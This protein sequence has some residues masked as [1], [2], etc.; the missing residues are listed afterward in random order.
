MNATGR[1]PGKRKHKLGGSYPTVSSMSRTYGSSTERR[2]D[3]TLS[4]GR[5][6]LDDIG[7]GIDRMINAIIN[8]ELARERSWDE[9]LANKEKER[10]VVN[11]V[12][13]VVIETAEAVKSAPSAI[14]DFFGTQHQDPALHGGRSYATKGMGKRVIDSVGETFSAIGDRISKNFTKTDAM[15]AVTGLGAGF[16]RGGSLVAGGVNSLISGNPAD[17]AKAAG[18]FIMSNEKVRKVMEKFGKVM[19]KILDP[20]AEVFVPVFEALG[21][22]LVEFAEIINSLL[23]LFQ[24]LAQA[25]SN[26]ARIAGSVM[27]PIGSFVDTVMNAA[28]SVF[29]GIAG[30]F[31]GGGGKSK[32]DRISDS[33]RSSIK[34]I[35]NE[36][37]E[38]FKRNDPFSELLKGFDA[39]YDQADRINSG[40]KKRGMKDEIDRARAELLLAEV[41][42]D[43]IK[44]IRSLEGAL[45]QF[46]E[47]IGLR[48]HQVYDMFSASGQLSFVDAI[49]V[50]GH[51]SDI[52]KGM[53]SGSGVYA[54]GRIKDFFKREM[55]LD[56]DGKNVLTSNLTGDQALSLFIGGQED[57]HRLVGQSGKVD[58]QYIMKYSGASDRASINY[59]GQSFVGMGGLS[60]MHLE[61]ALR[62]AL[63]QELSL[64]TYD[65]RSGSDSSSYTITS[66]LETGNAKDAVTDIMGQ[67]F[68]DT[69]IGKLMLNNALGVLDDAAGSKVGSYHHY[70]DGNTYSYGM[71]GSRDGAQVTGG[72]INDMVDQ[73]LTIPDLFRE[74]V[75]SIGGILEQG[76]AAFDYIAADFSDS[77][78]FALQSVE[79]A[80]HDFRDKDGNINYEYDPIKASQNIAD[81]SN[82][83]SVEAHNIYKSQDFSEAFRQNPRGQLGNQR[84]QIA[85]ELVNKLMGAEDDT[86]KRS[87]G[88]RDQLSK[89]DPVKDAD[90]YLAVAK[91]IQIANEEAITKTLQLEIQKAESIRTQTEN[92]Q[93]E[94]NLRSI[95]EQQASQRIQFE[96]EL[97][98][99]GLGKFTNTQMSL[100][101]DKYTK[102]LQGLTDAF[103]ERIYT[104]DQILKMGKE[105]EEMLESQNEEYEKLMA[106]F[107]RKQLIE[108]ERTNR[109][110]QESFEDMEQAAAG[111]LQPLRGAISFLR[112]DL[113]DSLKGLTTLGDKDSIIQS[114]NRQIANAI[115]DAGATTAT[116]LPALEKFGSDIKAIAEELDI[117]EASAEKLIGTVE[118]LTTQQEA[119]TEAI[120]INTELE[121][122]RAK[123]TLSGSS[124]LIDLIDFE[125]RLLDI[126]NSQA[127]NAP[128]L[129]E[130]E[131]QLLAQR[132]TEELRDVVRAGY[133]FSSSI[134]SIQDTYQDRIE[135]NAATMAI[136]EE[137]GIG[138]LS[139]D[140]LA[141]YNYAKTLNEEL[142]KAMAREI[143]LENKKILDDI[144]EQGINYSELGGA[145][146]SFIGNLE[147]IG[148]AHMMDFSLESLGKDITD[149]ELFE[150]LKDGRDLTKEQNDQIHAAIAARRREIDLI[151]KANR[152]ESINKMADFFGVEDDS[153]TYSQFVDAMKSLEETLKS[154]D[155]TMEDLYYSDF[156]PTPFVNKL[157]NAEE[158]YGQLYAAAM[159]MNEDG[160]YNAEAI[161]EFQSYVQTYL[162][163]QRDIYKSSGAYVAAYEKVQKDLQDV[164]NT[165]AIYGTKNANDRLIEGME[166]LRLELIALGDHE[167]FAGEVQGLIGQMKDGLPDG[168]EQAYS[169]MKTASTQ[170]NVDVDQITGQMVQTMRNAAISLNRD[171][172]GLVGDNGS[173]SKHISSFT[174]KIG[175]SSTDPNTIPGAFQ[176]LTT[177]IQ[178]MLNSIQVPEVATAQQDATGGVN[179]QTETQNSGTKDATVTTTGGGSHAPS[180]LPDSNSNFQ[181]HSMTEGI[182]GQYDF[183]GNKYDVDQEVVGKFHNDIGGRTYNSGQDFIDTAK[184]KTEAPLT[185]WFKHNNKYYAFDKSDSNSLLAA[186]NIISAEDFAGDAGT[187]GFLKNGLDDSSMKPIRDAL[188]AIGSIVQTPAAESTPETPEVPPAAKLL[189]TFWNT[190]PSNGKLNAQYVGSPEGMIGPVTK[191][192]WEKWRNSSQATK[193]VNEMLDAADD[194]GWDMSNK[195]DWYFSLKAFKSNGRLFGTLWDSRSAEYLAHA[196]GNTWDENDQWAVLANAARYHYASG[197]YISGRSHAQ[198][199]VPIEA[200]G[201]EYIMRK[202]A[203]DK[204]GVP[205]MNYLN[206]EGGLPFMRFGMGEF[207]KQ[208]AEVG[209]AEVNSSDGE[210]KSLIRELIYAIK[211]GDKDIAD[212]IEE[213][214]L[215]PEISVFTD[216]TGEIE[217]QIVAYDEKIREKSKRGID[218]RRNR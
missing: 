104:D 183:D 161:S 166:K 212:A 190:D 47:D 180:G 99:Q 184:E 35:N 69:D 61:Q 107:D 160:S 36:Y 85:N 117:S 115:N 167:G 44:S 127:E 64:R 51:R 57:R 150:E 25:I 103:G 33:I 135:G 54:D 56:A 210:L 89:L 48:L 37:F 80:I 111:T 3:E 12:K 209:T 143:A 11:A 142:P 27:K 4:Y 197:G 192:S 86:G 22:L 15:N 176:S 126:R 70:S 75:E 79:D 98:D 114:T 133:E 40:S 130:L 194:A 169:E 159:T 9:Y 110:V 170:M 141:T 5:T 189:N 16:G 52:A 146:R 156:N 50:T 119:Q 152:E 93:D 102:N 32:D 106:L 49:N 92:L 21:E 20:L 178:T 171:F 155:D 95:S 24:M 203:V 204:M 66:F 128:E 144:N 59:D 58:G 97:Y 151:N 154:L 206:E 174:K 158:K 72:Y 148:A 84:D 168:L 138:T 182:K 162:G 213:M 14:S 42:K 139:D 149:A 2:P 67:Y 46:G 122:L 205:F 82:M 112:Y 214:E 185:D 1:V 186:W 136:F 39:L 120:E 134:Q 10:I 177:R 19:E 13:E 187:L 108:L 208:D 172:S 65:A 60:Q 164:S 87:G 200:E 88:L 218:P 121:I 78:R 17:M 91:K 198:G 96:K 38:Q 215:H 62:Y 43:L 196:K 195:K 132:R 116:A 94:L 217:A 163:Y 74:A 131:R 71:D 140:Q 8:S 53:A 147:T 31:G 105:Y 216:L 153:Y 100:E 6:F 26:V 165:A 201:G 34:S 173:L 145:N 175:G 7:E 73:F 123:A 113:P 90:A 68:G 181:I 118:G 28:T 125:Q 29:N 179:I 129:I 76:K 207:M 109:Q 211:E 77:V 23:P 63:G 193:A 157:E 81:I 18:N 30:I 41:N 199:G 83:L 55:G 188:A 202:S 124:A 137:M 191:E 45:T 101:V